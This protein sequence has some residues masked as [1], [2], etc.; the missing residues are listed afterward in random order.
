MRNTIEDI[1]AKIGYSKCLLVSY[2]SKL[3]T[4]QPVRK[5]KFVFG[6][7]YKNYDVIL[8]FTR[9]QFKKYCKVSSIEPNEL[10]CFN[11]FVF[12]KIVKFKF[13]LDSDVYEAKI[14]ISIFKNRICQNSE[15]IV[16]LL[17]DVYLNGRILNTPTYISDVNII[18]KSFLSS[19]KKYVINKNISLYPEKIETDYSYF[20]VIN[21]H[22]NDFKYKASSKDLIKSNIRFNLFIKSKLPSVYD[23]YGNNKL[24]K[25]IAKISSKVYN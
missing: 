14:P 3:F 21:F 17:E 22:T 4:T 18:T 13:I 5:Y 19:D 2:S 16:Y 6:M 20:K 7:I 12:D 9:T 23:K 25:L 15:S 1:V 10:L 8:G 24:Y 11:I